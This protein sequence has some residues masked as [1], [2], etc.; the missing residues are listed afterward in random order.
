MKTHVRVAVIGGGV[1][2]C[3][4]LYHLTKLGWK[5]VVLLERDELTCG[6]TWHAAGGMHTLNGDPNVAKLQKYTIEL[7]KEIEE[8]SGLSCGLHLPGGLVLAGTP[9]RMDWLRMAQARG[10]YLGLDVH[11]VDMAEAKRRMPLI[12]ESA[13]HRRHVRPA[14]GPSRSVRHH[15]RLRARGDA[16]R[17]RKSIAR[18]RWN[19]CTSA[20]TA[21]GTWSPTRAPSS[22]NTSSTAAASGR[23]RSGA[24][25]ASNCRSWRWSTITSSPRTSR[26]I[27]RRTANCRT[28]STSRARS[29]CARSARACCSAPTSA[30]ACRGR[31]RRRRGTSPPS[32]CRPTWSGSRPISKSGS[33]ISRCWPRPA[34]AASSTARSPSRPTA[35]RWSGRCAACAI[36]GSPAA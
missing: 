11:I 20:P 2:G 17:A 16:S 24:W 22:P 34:S 18:P 7:Y 1:V 19:R 23:A 6:S 5:D 10:R 15:A 31:R 35:I 36:S 21:A 8:I 28:S 12:D 27:C 25:S 32:C 3:S 14:G 9:E 30:T 29:I 13:L 33:S 4:V 26:S